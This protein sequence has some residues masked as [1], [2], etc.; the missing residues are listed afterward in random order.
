MASI[1][2]RNNRWEVRVR[3]SGYPTQTK[4]FT[5]KSSAQ[6][7]AR[8]AELALEQGKLTCRPQCLSMTLELRSVDAL[9]ISKNRDRSEELGTPL[10]SVSL[11]TNSRSSSV[12]VFT[13]I[14][15]PIAC[16]RTFMLFIRFSNGVDNEARN[17]SSSADFS[18]IIS[19]A[20]GFL[21]QEKG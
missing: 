10:P 18:V 15:K 11:R 1:R 4:T 13:V 21:N 17:V 19:S 12:V 16:S 2:K 8:V 6:T 9:A 20:S 3:R 14:G 5:H 7:W